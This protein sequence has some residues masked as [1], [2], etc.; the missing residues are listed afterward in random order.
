VGIFSNI[1]GGTD[2]RAA[3]KEP[4]RPKKLLCVYFRGGN[5]MRMPMLGDDEATLTAEAWADWAKQP[6]EKRH[7]D[8]FIGGLGW[9]FRCEDV[10]AVSADVDTAAENRAAHERLRQE[11]READERYREQQEKAQKYQQ[12]LIKLLKKQMGGGEEWRQGDDEG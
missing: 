6:R 4:E 8:H 7:P 9:G 1:L 11:Q 5:T 12:E 3:K 10:V 2:D